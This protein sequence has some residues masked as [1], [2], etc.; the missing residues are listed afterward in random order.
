MLREELARLEGERGRVEAQALIEKKGD[1][2]G[3]WEAYKLRKAIEAAE[4]SGDT[5]I[6]TQNTIQSRAKDV[7][8]A[9]ESGI[10]RSNNVEASS[11]E[12]K[13]IDEANDYAKSVMDY[14]IQKITFMNEATSEDYQPTGYTIPGK[15]L[16]FGEKSPHDTRSMRKYYYENVWGDKLVSIL[17]NDYYGTFSSQSEGSYLATMSNHYYNWMDDQDLLSPETESLQAMWKKSDQVF[18]NMSEQI[19]LGN[20]TEKVTLSGTIGQMLLALA[21]IDLIAD[22]RDITFDITNWENSGSHIGQTAT[23]LIGLFPIIG[24]V[25][26]ADELGLLFKQAD[27]LKHSDEAATTFKGGSTV[28]LGDCNCF[29]AGTKVQTDEGEKPIEEI[30]VGDKVLAKDENNPDGELAY[31]EVTALYRN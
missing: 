10:N 14:Q 11:L 4:D 26:S 3:S 5:S 1:D 23:D 24:V 29:T 17:K 12:Q 18:M 13:I 2:A 8:L 7:V 21:G 30:E 25:K 19:L 16:L 31:K 27:D 15:S 28:K 20:W 6:R 22:L 9:L